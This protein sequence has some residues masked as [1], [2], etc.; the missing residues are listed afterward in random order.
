[1]IGGAH[2]PRLGF[3][4]SAHVA[5]PFMRHLWAVGALKE[6]WGPAPGPWVLFLACWG[7][8][9]CGCLWGEGLYGLQQTC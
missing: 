7:V 6:I 1:M 8:G 4:K 2:A 3:R 5:S 9:A